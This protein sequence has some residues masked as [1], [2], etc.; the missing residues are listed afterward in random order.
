MR[1]RKLLLIH[2]TRSTR[3]L[4]K[5][6]IFSE[7]G[8]IEI[9]EA[10]SGSEAAFA[11]KNERFDVIIAP[12]ELKDMSIAEFRQELLAVMP[13]NA[14]PLIIISESESPH[15]RN[16]LVEQGFDRVVQIRLRPSDLIQKINAV[17]DPRTWRKD[18]RYHLANVKATIEA[19]DRCA[20]ATLINI[21]KGGILVELAC[22]QP[23]LLMS[24]QIRIGLS[25]DI[26]DGRGN[27]D[28][29]TARLSRI[30][31]LG[32]E[33]AGKPNHM[34]ATFIFTDLPDG[35]KGKLNELLKTAKEEKLETVSAD[36]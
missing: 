17:C 24:E 30:E 16:E 33:S 34:R 3:G 13:H 4:I 22:E 7:L 32:W 19:K 31:V 35:P 12:D 27:I 15:V 29:L 11:L 6:Y 9:G 21:S 18:A 25:I 20:E 5:K 2:P 36:H 23:S 14:L 10:Q 28:G 8:D 26:N 1:V